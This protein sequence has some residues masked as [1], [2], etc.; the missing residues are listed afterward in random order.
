MAS[1]ACRPAAAGS[2]STLPIRTPPAYAT[3]LAV[4]G[5][6]T[7]VPYEVAAVSWSATGGN[8]GGLPRSR[9]PAL[10]TVRQTGL[11]Q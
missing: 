10:V 6:V 8:S 5:I 2:R 1:V 11:G 3:S 7:G 4:T 9:A